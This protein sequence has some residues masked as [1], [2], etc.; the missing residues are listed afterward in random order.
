M[1]SGRLHRFDRILGD[2]AAI[3]FDFDFELI[4]RQNLLSQL[5]DF[6]ETIRPETM[7]NVVPN[8]GL[9]Q[10]RFGLSRDP[11]AIDEVFHDVAHFGD[12]GV[13][14]DAI[15]VRQNE[16]GQSGWVLFEGRAE[17]R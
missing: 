6:R 14:R 16:A 2:D 11:A 4:V 3:V 10:N 12:V 5:E 17:I 9:K 7:L 8:V 13:R 15:A 1:F